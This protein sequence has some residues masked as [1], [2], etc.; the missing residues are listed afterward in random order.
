MRVALELTLV[1]NRRRVLLFLE[2]RLQTLPGSDSERPTLETGLALR[3]TLLRS[4]RRF[5]TSVGSSL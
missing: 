5:F 2:V 3:S 1:G 4:L